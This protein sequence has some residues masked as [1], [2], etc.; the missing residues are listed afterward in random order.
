[1]LKIL[2]RL[3]RVRY[4]FLTV[5]ALVF[6]VG[7]LIL[8]S[9]PDV[10]ES[11][12]ILAMERADEYIFAEESANTETVS[13]RVQLTISSVLRQENVIRH[14]TEQG[15]LDSTASETEKRESV[16]LFRDNAQIEF[17]NVSVINQYTGKFGL[18]SLG[19]LVS[20][21]SEDPTLAYAF[22]SALVN[23]V[24]QGIRSKANPNANQ[25]ESFL[26]KQLEASSLRLANIGVSIAD[27]KNE[28]AMYLPDLYPVTVR[29]FDEVS[30]RIERSRENIDSLQRERAT[31]LA[32]LATSSPEALMFSPDGTRIESPQ[33]KLQQ[34]RIDRASAIS[35]YSNRHPQI[36][37]LEREIAALE[38]FV[39][40]D[41]SRTLEV[42]LQ[43]TQ[44]KLETLRERYA[45][46]HPDVLSAQAQLA[47]RDSI[48]E[49]IGRE[50]RR[51]NQL[52]DRREEIQDQ[53]ARMPGIEQ[54]MEE[55]ERLQ[56]REEQAY[57]ELEKQLTAAQLSSNM[58]DA[59]LLERFVVVEP[60]NVPLEPV[61]PHRRLLL[62][63]LMLLALCAAVSATLLRLTMLDAIWGRQDLGNLAD[64]SVVLIPR[65]LFTYSQ[66]SSSVASAASMYCAWSFVGTGCCICPWL[67]LNILGR[68]PNTS[69]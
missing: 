4:T 47:R 21:R 50:S 66:S 63:V 29:Q 5:F 46:A 38:K 49:E 14:L 41:D 12:G 35:R 51:L 13:R 59:D 7:Y 27:F 39:G 61:S 68:R 64:S 32:E 30:T 42:E 23:D 15:V 69:A 2:Q 28:N 36:I 9:L 48:V 56:E 67:Y 24:V 40:A 6:S 17:D 53:L 62:M 8:S 60:P 65:W 57:S 43:Q 10:Y 11:S 3:M 25:T 54:R 55:I 58:Q 52:E 26:S 31:A 18:L 45:E 37:S 19:L 33:E 1:V 22:T 20:Y 34:L 16:A 44:A